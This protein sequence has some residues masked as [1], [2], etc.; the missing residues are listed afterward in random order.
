LLSQFVIYE[1]AH[2]QAANNLQH[3]KIEAPSKKEQ[4]FIN[5]TL[6]NAQVIN[7]KNN[8]STNTTAINGKG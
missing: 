7:N 5:K 6:G 4:I 2:R 3:H 8:N 1:F